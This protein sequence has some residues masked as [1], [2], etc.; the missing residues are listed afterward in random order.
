MRSSSIRRSE[1]PRRPTLATQEQTRRHFIFAENMG[2][3]EPQFELPHKTIKLNEHALREKKTHVVKHQQR[4]TMK[5]SHETFKKDYISN[6]PE[7]TS[8]KER[9]HVSHHKHSHTKSHVPH[10]K[11]G[12]I[13]TATGKSRVPR[14]HQK[15]K[16]KGYVPNKVRFDPKAMQKIKYLMT[17]SSEKDKKFIQYFISSNKD[18]K[19][20]KNQ[21]ALKRMKVMKKKKVHHVG[22]KRNKVHKKMN[23]RNELDKNKAKAP[24][25]RKIKSK[26]K[27]VEKKGKEMKINV[28]KKTHVFGM[29]M[30]HK[31]LIE[32]APKKTHIE[33]H[34]HKVA[35]VTKK[36]ET[37]PKTTINPVTTKV[38]LTPNTTSTLSHK[39]QKTLIVAAKKLE[40]AR[41]KSVIKNRKEERLSY[42]ANRIPMKMKKKTKRK[43]GKNIVVTKHFH[44]HNTC[45]TIQGNKITKKTLKN[46]LK[47][48]TYEK[49][50]MFGRKKT[51]KN[52]LHKLKIKKGSKKDSITYKHNHKVRIGPTAKKHSIFM[53]SS[54]PTASDASDQNSALS[55]FKKNY[56]D[57]KKKA[58][59][60]QQKYVIVPYSKMKQRCPENQKWTGDRCSD[61][62]IKPSSYANATSILSQIPH[63]DAKMRMVPLTGPSEPEIPSIVQEMAPAMP[64]LPS[65]EIAFSQPS[66]PVLPRGEVSS[67]LVS[68][69]TVT[70]G[71]PEAFH[72]SEGGGSLQ[73]LLQAVETNQNAELPLTHEESIAAARKIAKDL[74]GGKWGGAE[75]PEMT[76]SMFTLAKQANIPPDI[77]LS[78]F[79]NH[80]RSSNEL[81]RFENTPRDGKESNLFEQL[82]P[83]RTDKTSTVP[84]L[85]GTIRPLTV[86]EGNTVSTLPEP[87]DK[88]FTVITNIPQVDAMNFEK[89]HDYERN[90]KINAGIYQNDK[91]NS[92]EKI[93]AGVNR[94][95]SET[96]NVAENFVHDK[97]AEYYQNRNHLDPESFRNVKDHQAFNSH[98][99]LKKEQV[100]SERTN[101]KYTSPEKVF[102]TEANSENAKHSE[103]ARIGRFSNNLKEHME[104]S[105]EPMN[106]KTHL[107]AEEEAIHQLDMAQPD[108]D[109]DYDFS[110]SDPHRLS[111]TKPATYHA[112]IR[113]KTNANRYPDTEHP[114]KV[115]TSK[116]CTVNCKEKTKKTSS[117]A[118]S[119]SAADAD[120]ESQSEEEH[121]GEETNIEEH[122]PEEVKSVKGETGETK[123]PP[124]KAQLMMMKNMVNDIIKTRMGQRNE[125]EESKS[126]G[127]WRET[128]HGGHHNE[129]TSKDFYPV[130]AVQKDEQQ[131][132]VVNATVQ[133]SPQP[134][135]KVITGEEGKEFQSPLI[136]RLVQQTTG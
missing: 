30:H 94:L 102:E 29:Q 65:N 110:T 46:K 111:Y 21:L 7:S 37:N 115:V 105:T 64:F 50:R 4:K 11:K 1:I 39:K 9:S 133:S 90:E 73:P 8:H 89:Q 59:Q 130:V 75:T 134:V 63:T 25:Q 36:V 16:K 5:K 52:T 14:R 6:K 131:K 103:P 119:S 56:D 84:T 116:K 31:Q 135:V 18:L 47:K 112:H 15:G 33:K 81:L 28:M 53:N 42:Q 121:K 85:S 126:G 54:F 57:L 106:K 83:E 82:R 66:I 86:Q 26:E 24:H 96:L 74:M 136:T 98:E 62:S 35:P 125:G 23:R 69:D 22:R 61:D 45:Y 27:K 95:D 68:N 120:Q 3:F 60:I 104:K 12:K 132:L 20:L 44:I 40:K 17:H 70:N 123:S 127:E 10:N 117:P 71:I 78:H 49:K 129:E 48:I 38:E 122:K 58:S 51:A 107:T 32:K 2:R 88:G 34:Q 41:K 128:P 13:K 97:I 79:N 92:Y 113:R 114:A 100:Q 93:G 124:P 76:S 91:S 87:Q 99:K 101:Q 108:P 72:Q 77:L 19:E 80:G 118:S 55:G 43:H 109:A 67:R